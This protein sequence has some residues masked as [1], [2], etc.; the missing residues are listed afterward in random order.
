MKKVLVILLVLASASLAMPQQ[1]QRN[2]SF[3]KLNVRNTAMFAQQIVSTITTGTAPFSIASTTV[4]PNLNAALLNGQPGIVYSTASASTNAS[5][6]AVTMATASGSGNTYRFSLYIDQ[7][8]AGTSC[9]G[10]T[11]ITPNII[12]TDRTHQA[13]FH[14]IE[15]R[16]HRRERH[17]GEIGGTVG[18]VWTFNF[19]AKA[20]TVVQYS[21]T[22][23]AGE[24]A[25]LLRNTRFIRYLS[26]F[27][28][29]SN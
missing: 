4:V 27:N 16:S 21:V 17:T 23:S 3:D 14:R 2:A 11:T 10:T 12:Y 5:I 25:R 28:E 26:S 24:A 18:S 8:V 20:S 9:V 13:V 6:S 15:Q 19:R 1:T 29:E 22:Y 7:T